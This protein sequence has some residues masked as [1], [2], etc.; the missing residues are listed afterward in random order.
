L[1]FIAEGEGQVFLSGKTGDK[2]NPVCK[3]DL[4]IINPGIN[5]YE[6]YQQKHL[7]DTPLC[8]Y[9]CS[10]TDFETSIM[11]SN[12]LL[13]PN[14]PLI[15]KTEKMADRFLSVFIEMFEE[16]EGGKTWYAEICYNLSCE[17]IT[18]MLRLLHEKYNLSL[19]WQ[20]EHH[21]DR[22]KQ[23][24]DMHYAEK[25]DSG[26]IAE[27]LAMSRYTLFRIF[28]ENNYSLVQYINQ[29][30]IETAKSLI[31]EGRDSIQEIAF[32]VGYSDY[33]SFF[34]NFKKITGFSPKE[35]CRQ[36]PARGSG[37]V[38]EEGGL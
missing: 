18:L 37:I 23:F 17:I 1:L 31:R 21:I 7:N 36:L 25:I 11:P 12:Q 33:S 3:G 20:N 5:H 14:F 26:T 22:I 8:I 27:Q 4:V 10:I 32:R 28:H 38:I 35:Y 9:C 30:R 19:Q 2:L 16:N 6:R 34:M 24:V 13:P 29:K 15:L